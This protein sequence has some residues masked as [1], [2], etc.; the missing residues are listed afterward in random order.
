MYLNNISIHVFVTYCAYNQGH[1][2]IYYIL[3]KYSLT[4]YIF[5]GINSAKSLE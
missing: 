2:L 5:S 1:Q 3:W 4:K